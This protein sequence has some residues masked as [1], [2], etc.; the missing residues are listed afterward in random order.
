V[1]FQNMIPISWIQ[2]FGFCEYSV[3]L[4]EIENV[5]VEPTEK[6]VT[7][8]KVHEQLY[9]KFLVTAKPSTIKQMINKSKKS[10][11]LSRELYVESERFGLIGRIDEIHFSPENFVIIDDKPGNTVYTSNKN[12]VFAYCLAFIDYA[13]QWRTKGDTRPMIAALR[14]RDSQKIIWR[15]PF[16]ATA[17][18]SII[19]EINRLQSMI[20][21]EQP[22]SP[23]TN[24]NKCRNCSVRDSCNKKIV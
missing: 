20:E 19:S 22:F 10:E 14:E 18:N 17:Q 21:G 24:C 2:Q 23:T 8:K 13:S 15:S 7:G 16:N 5:D 4:R 1:T 11:Q 6:M 12:Q 9:E 3:F